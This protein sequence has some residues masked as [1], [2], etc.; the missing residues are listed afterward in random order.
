[1]QNQ[2]EITSYQPLFNDEG[3][4]ANPGWA[5]KM[6][7]DFDVTKMAAPYKKLR[8][9]DYYFIG[10]DEL[11]VAITTSF[12]GNCS[13]AIVQLMKFKEGLCLSKMVL[14][15]EDIHQ[16]K[17]DEGAVYMRT[18][19]TE[20]IYIRKPGKHIMKLWLKD[21][22]QGQDLS[23]NLVLT[24]PED[25]DRMVIATPFTEGKELFF[26]NEKLNCMKVSG[27]VHLGDTVYTMSPDK[28]YAV[29][30]FGRGVWP[31]W[32]RW[33]WGS[34]SGEWNGHL[35]GW[36]IGYGFGD[37]S[38]ATENMIFFDGVAHKFDEIFFD[39]PVLGFT[40]G[41]WHI[42]SNDG[43]FDMMFTPLYD[44]QTISDLMSPPCALQHQVFGYYTGKCYLDDGTEIEV[45]DYFGFA[46][47]VYNNWT[48]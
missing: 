3:I 4:L 5:R 47:D 15:D 45:K 9:W 33:Y 26:F 16:P 39:I 7:F 31:D 28:D 29:L 21:F 44:R 2:N 43:R 35:L 25:T 48:E 23:W 1:M 10:G 20:V 41:D 13:R 40:N 24:Y 34:A 11:G 22:H 37:L 19:E 32:N 38:N 36:N 42:Y 17:D 14:T 46:E 6:Y 27:T 8:A 12:R 30:D 18:D